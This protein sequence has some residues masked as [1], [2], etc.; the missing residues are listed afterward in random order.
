MT[1]I[2]I[3]RPGGRTSRTRDAVHAA[4]RDLR[5]QGK[6]VTIADVAVLSGVHPATIYRRWRSAEALVV[7]VEVDRL[8]E[9]SPI[10]STGDLKMDLTSYTR[11]LVNSLRQPE[12]LDF[13]RALSRVSVRDDPEAATF[14][15][16]RINQFDHM[17]Q[18]SGTMHLTG[19]DIFEL[20]LAPAYAWAT[21]A[22]LPPGNA[23]ADRLTDNVIA[24]R[25]RRRTQR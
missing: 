10:S 2:R 11:A 23:L 22:K 5:E 9:T 12:G 8:T 16:R 6:P 4:V 20:I 21:L 14:L 1:D 3:S 25:D 17:L 7:D 19:Y 24:V 18:A 15:S 13:F